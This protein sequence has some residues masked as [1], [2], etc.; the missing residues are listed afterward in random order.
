MIYNTAGHSGVSLLQSMKHRYILSLF[1]LVLPLC[2]VPLQAQ[3]SD[4][5][6]LQEAL[7]RFEQQIQKGVEISFV[8][9]GTSVQPPQQGYM[10]LAGVR[11]TLHVPGILSAFDGKTLRVIDQTERT[12]TLMTPSQQDLAVMNPLAYLNMPN[13]HY[14]IA[15]GQQGAVSYRFVPQGN[16]PVLSGVKHYEVQF[17][18]KSRQPKQVDLYFDSGDQ[19]TYAIRKIQP[20]EHITAQSFTFAPQEYQALE[21]IDLR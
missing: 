19:V 6:D 16:R 8:M 1:L 18:R 17:D 13:K 7:S 2:A 10:W 3:K 15:S 20:K 9:S 11:F 4:T 5:F 14:R 12:Y 21:V